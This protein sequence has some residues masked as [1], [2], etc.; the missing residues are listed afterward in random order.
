MHRFGIT[1]S[2]SIGSAVVRN[3]YKRWCRELYR[4]TSMANLKEPL[5]INL[6]LG[7]KQLKKDD[8]KNATFGEFK[9]QFDEAIKR[10][11]KTFS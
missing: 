5:D 3:Q 7:N 1:A 11:I 4:K 2:K 9:D 10:L 6:F 8:F